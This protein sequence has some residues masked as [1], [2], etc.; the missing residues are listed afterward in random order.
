MKYLT[1]LLI[2]CFFSAY[3]KSGIYCSKQIDSTKY[4]PHDIL[5]LEIQ[6]IEEEVLKT[7]EPISDEALEKI[8]SLRQTKNFVCTNGVDPSKMTPSQYIKT[9][10]Q[11]PCSPAVA[12]PGITG[13]KLVAKIDCETLKST[14]PD[15]FR[16]CGWTGCTSLLSSK[17]KKEYRIWV[18]DLTSPMS[19]I[20]PYGSSKRCFAGLLG[21]DTEG[22]GT[23]FKIKPK[24]GVTIDTL[25]STPDIGDT[26][27]S[28][29]CGWD[30]ISNILP[31]S[32]K[33]KGTV[34]WG[35][36]IDVLLSAG[37]KLGVTV[38]A[39]PYDFR[40]DVRENLLN[41]KFK[42]VINDMN[43]MLG[44]KVTILAH[45]FGNFQTAN[46]LWNMSQAEKDAKIARY[47]GIAPPFSGAVKPMLSMI[48]MDSTYSKKLVIAKVGLTE[49]CFTRSFFMFKGVYNLFPQNHYEDHSNQEYMKSI[50]KKINAESKATDPP[51]GTVMDIFP[52]FSDEC[53]VGFKQRPDNCVLQ[54]KEFLNFGSIQSTQINSHT[55]KDLLEN[56]SHSP[57]AEI[58]YEQAKDNRFA[59]LENLGV[60]TNILFSTSL[61]TYS[62]IHYYND[63]KT[64]TNDGKIYD[65]DK[66]EY[67]PGDGSVLATSALTAAI[68]WADEFMFKRV[69]GAKPVTFIEACSKY[70]EKKSIFQENKKVTRNEYMG[71]NC[72]CRGSKTNRDDG[73]CTSHTQML[74]D[75]YIID[76]L[77]NSLIDGETGEVGGR[78][79]T[80]NDAQLKSYEQNCEMFNKG[81]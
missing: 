48:G 36:L 24:A 50:M 62:K 10:A 49:D 70:N 14:D 39:L 22:S 52:K 21:F 43:E 63:P 3:L 60:Q 72:Y 73:M 30:A 57:N 29:K 7:L 80:M 4:E 23:N 9:F 32:I 35:H 13:S 75:P 33:Y 8:E 65:P 20:K 53:V 51:I 26:S 31:L 27:S 58:I 12:V 79:K 59:T 25:G 11:G 55:L 15:T 18:P 19:I 34:V 44:K 16:A 42:K 2:L 64:K 61:P 45:S 54:M 78:F 46:F 76:F 37:Y 69:S 5:E 66:V 1:Y 68:K 28:N 77:F 41:R 40:I 6:N 56:H 74:E 38:Q 47:I 17:P 71:T 67:A 81:Y